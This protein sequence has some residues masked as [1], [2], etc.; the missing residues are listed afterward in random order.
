M[1]TYTVLFTGPETDWTAVSEADQAD[2]QA[3]H[4]AFATACI[5]RGWT[6]HAGAELQPS[7]TARTLAR[8][9][10]GSIAVT[11]G[12]Y[13]ELTEH[14]GGFYLIETDDLDGLVELV[15]PLMWGQDVI[16]IRPIVDRPAA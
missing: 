6:V 12:P 5:E 16:S 13:A 2:L 3:K 8:S 1:T 7:A 10:D 15:K 14:I 4:Y 9:Q 11:D